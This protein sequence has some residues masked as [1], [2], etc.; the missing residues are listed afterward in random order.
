MSVKL[1]NHYI[2]GQVNTKQFELDEAISRK[3]SQA[4]KQQRLAKI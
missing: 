4:I 3:I 2:G 1:S